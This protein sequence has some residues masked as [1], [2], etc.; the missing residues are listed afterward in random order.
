MLD[1]DTQVLAFVQAAL[2]QGIREAEALLAKNPEIGDTSLHVAAIRGDEETVA[3]LLHAAPSTF[4]M[5]LGPNW[6]PLL[7]LAHSHYAS[8]DSPGAEG[9]LGCAKLLLSAGADAMRGLPDDDIPGGIAT[10]LCGAAGTGNLELCEVL[11]ARGAIADDGAAL[12]LA[13][14]AEN[15]DCARA[16]RAA[17]A[18]LGP[19]A[20]A[21]GQTPL[22]WMLDVRS[23]PAAIQRL[24]DDGADPNVRVGERGETALHV[25]VRRRRLEL[26]D[27]LIAAGAKVDAE[28]TGGMTA[29]RHALRRPFQEICARLAKHGASTEVTSG[30][31]LALALHL[32]DLDTA[33]SK[34]AAAALETWSAEECRLLPDVASAG[35]FEAMQFL[36]DG[37]LDIA[38]RG[39]DGGTALHQAAWFGQ[40]VI[41]RLLVERGAPLG[42]RGDVHDSTPLGWLAHGSRWSGGADARQDDYTQVAEILMAAGAP[43]PGAADRHD[44]PQLAQASD[45]VRAVLLKGERGPGGPE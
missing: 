22:H 37:G 45:A 12:F 19:S 1:D 8:P 23:V 44:H 38:S 39:L 26:I 13:V 29:W 20:A 9:V 27:P 21:G 41:A 30:D 43:L 34:L 18:P 24:L 14:A 4:D 7:L 6:R 17:G 5:E 25:A 35:N 36:L 40:P 10:P 33:R 42:V 31:E 32:G 28:T 11:L 2:G 16:L 15:W 3:S